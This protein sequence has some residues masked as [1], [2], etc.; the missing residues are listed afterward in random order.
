[1]GKIS[2]LEVPSTSLGTGSSTARY[3]HMSRNQSERRSAQDDG[4][5]AS[6][7]ALSARYS[8]QVNVAVEDY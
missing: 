6:E 8:P 7:D 4:F 5:V 2:A 3:R 1:M